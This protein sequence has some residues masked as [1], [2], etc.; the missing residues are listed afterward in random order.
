MYISMGNDLVWC[1][2]MTMKQWK[3]NT[4]VYVTYND[5]YDIYVNHETYYYSR[6]ED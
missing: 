5:A 3:D 6:K 2:P 4:T 1:R